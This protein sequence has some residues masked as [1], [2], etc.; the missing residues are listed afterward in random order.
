M[1]F[2]WSNNCFS[3]EAKAEPGCSSCGKIN[4]KKKCAGCKR[5][6]YCNQKCQRF[7]WSAAEGAT[8]GA[9]KLFCSKIENLL[10]HFKSV[11]NFSV[12]YTLNSVVATCVQQIN[13]SGMD[14]TTISR[15]LIK[16]LQHTPV[17]IEGNHI[18]G[19]DIY[20]FEDMNEKCEEFANIN[21][22]L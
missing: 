13:D 20:D 21:Q 14:S 2:S 19:F 1:S 3:L 10:D 4:P 16:E 8:K 17:R 11:R 7:A 5:A 15:R 6:W 9:H 18:S 12:M 22:T